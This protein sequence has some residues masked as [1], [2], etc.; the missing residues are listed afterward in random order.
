MSMRSR[1]LIA[2]RKTLK[3][4]EIF[5]DVEGDLL[6]V[7]WGS[8]RGAI[9]EAVAKLRA[10]GHRV[11]A[12]NLRFLSP[13]EPGLE[14]IFGRFRRVMTVEINYSDELGDPVATTEHRRMAQLALL[15]RSETLVN[16]DCWSRVPGTPLS[17]GSIERALRG[18]LAILNGEV[19]K[20]SA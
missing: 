8:T 13:L 10:E 11:S 20:C 3:P 9:E 6:V 19:A 12:V 4:P 7:G 15:L 18:R 2:L 16:V 14:E 5:G 17:P 1:K